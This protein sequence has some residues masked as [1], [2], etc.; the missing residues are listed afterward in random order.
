MKKNII[1]FC[2]FVC[3]Q[4]VFAQ[5]K[6][7]DSLKTALSSAGKP[8]DR[9]N[10]LNAISQ[11]LGLYS[12]DIDS[13]S[14]IQLLQIAQQ[15]RDDSLLAISYN[16]IGQYISR[17]KGDNTNALDYYFK[18]IP[19]A[20][21][22]GDKRRLSSLYFDIALIYS[23]LQNNEESVKYIRKGGENLPD[24]THPL[25]DFM[26]AQYQRGMA[27]HFVINHQPDSALSYAQ[28]LTAT[29]RRAKSQ[30]FEHGALYLSGAA[31]ELEGDKEM[32]DL[33]YKKT[34]ALSDSVK[35]ITAIL[36]FNRA[37]IPFL[38][39]NHRL[40]EAKE[41]ASQLLAIGHQQDNNDFK[42]AGAGFMRQVLDSL[43][44]RDSAYY[45]SRIE[46]GINA[47]IF[48]DNNI[49]KLQAL[50]FN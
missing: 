48:D 6:T 22:A 42:L 46:A 30:L 34:I 26:L 19:L 1:L 37:Y 16:L 5:N 39:N 24:K 13:A 18:A 50:A 17:L 40:A 29:S 32:A 25:Y 7:I 8:I 44:N 21:K 31:Y 10:I 33:F 49:N 27:N 45:Y 35:S 15:L 4:T 38:L 23:N 2:F 47:R 12:G 28:A 43:G 3:L 11:N 9:F 20:E 36:R 14:C 41:Q